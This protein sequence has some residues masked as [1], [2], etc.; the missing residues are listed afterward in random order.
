MSVAIIVFCFLDLG[1]RHVVFSL[2]M[3]GK[4]Y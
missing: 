3:P 1:F 4:L 2:G